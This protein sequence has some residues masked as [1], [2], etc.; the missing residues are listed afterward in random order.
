MCRVVVFVDV[1]LSV[2]V[3]L[4]CVSSVSSLNV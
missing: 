4:S 2:C 1:H 3:V